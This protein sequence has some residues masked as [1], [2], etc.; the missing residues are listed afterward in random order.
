MFGRTS[1]RNPY[2]F[3]SDGGHFENLGVYEMI[4]RRCRTIVVV[5]AGCDPAYTFEDLGNA[6]RRARIDL[7]VAIEFPEGLPM[8]ADGAGHGNP[9]AAIGHIRYSATDA[10][11]H[12]GRLIYLKATLSGDEP[13]DVLNY[14]Q[15][16]PAFP[17]EPTSN[18]WFAEAQFESYR[19]LGLH[20]VLV[21]GA[22]ASA[23]D[24]IDG[25]VRAVS[26]YVVES[27]STSTRASTRSPESKPSV[28]LS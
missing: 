14:A 24:G 15:A 7:G 28:N 9:H 4:A 12:D 27:A 25:F 11:Q 6:I 21:A 22:G 23:A 8:T 1:S 5:D 10:A 13:V 2:V 16:H 17:H 26:G 18:Q 20:T 3:L 19:V